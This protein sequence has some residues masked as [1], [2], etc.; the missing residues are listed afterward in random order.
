MDRFFAHNPALSRGCEMLCREGN[1]D[2][3]HMRPPP[4]KG[5]SR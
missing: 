1:A 5:R 3:I 4:M 2:A